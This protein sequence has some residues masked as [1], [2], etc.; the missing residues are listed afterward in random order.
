MAK[1][2]INKLG[3]HKKEKGI[4]QAIRPNSL[5]KFKQRINPFFGL[6]SSPPATLFKLKNNNDVTVLSNSITPTI[7]KSDVNSNTDFKQ[8]AFVFNKKRHILGNSNQG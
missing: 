4:Y 1:I 3:I 2:N 5:H 7:L 6:I 8:I